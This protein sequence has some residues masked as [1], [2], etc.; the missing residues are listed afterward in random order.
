MTN[1]DPKPPRAT[2]PEEI[3]GGAT[4][5]VWMQVTCGGACGQRGLLRAL[6]L[7]LRED[8]DCPPPAS[9]CGRP[10]EHSVVRVFPLSSGYKGKTWSTRAPILHPLRDVVA[11]HGHV[12]SQKSRRLAVPSRVLGRL[13][14]AGNGAAAALHTAVAA[15]CFPATLPRLTG[16]PQQPCDVVCEISCAVPPTAFS[17][18]KVVAIRVLPGSM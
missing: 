2:S 11:A 14:H 8:W 10:E 6:R 1:S 5:A 16:P 3:R 12:N 7:P 18:L 13:G 4:G 9:N 17:F 15:S